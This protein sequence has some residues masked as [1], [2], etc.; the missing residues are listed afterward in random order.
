MASSP[1][2]HDPAA[3]ALQAIEEALNLRAELDDPFANGDASAEDQMKRDVPGARSDAPADYRRK[4]GAA[5]RLPS[6][7]EEPLFGPPRQS[8]PAASAE[9]P[10]G[11][12]GRGAPPANDDRHSAGAILRAYQTRPNRAPTIIAALCSTLWIALTV[13]FLATNREQLFAGS[14]SAILPTAALYF[15]TI[16][17]PVVFFFITAMMVRRG[18]EMRVTTRSMTEVALRLA[19]PE[20]I[21]TEQMVTLSQAIRREVASMGDGIERALAR[22]GELETLVR[23]EVSNLERSF[24]D[25]E[26]RVR[27]LIDELAG[28]R[29]SI[30]ANADRVR[31]AISIAHDSVTRDI[32]FGVGSLR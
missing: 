22:A 30:L 11:Q 15:L 10:G 17:G 9:A 20:T 31:G 29:E 23:S 2:I 26:R 5:A 16:A 6:T 19:E 32:E 18:Q 3:E 13:G 24:S 14:N 27:A 1:K 7:S 21:A 25:N 8:A 28:E 12:I 4:S